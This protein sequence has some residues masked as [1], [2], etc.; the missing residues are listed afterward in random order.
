[1]IMT[2]K[3]KPDDVW[4]VCI[5]YSNEKIPIAVFASVRMAAGYAEWTGIATSIEQ[6]PKESIALKN[7]PITSNPNFYY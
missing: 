3:R 7:I 4:V 6:F 5:Y 1:M 2:H